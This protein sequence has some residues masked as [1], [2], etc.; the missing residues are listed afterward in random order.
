MAQTLER[1]ELC[2]LHSIRGKSPR[3]STPAGQFHPI[4][5]ERAN[6]QSHMESCHL[7]NPRTVVPGWLLKDWCV[8]I[9]GSER[10]GPALGLAGYDFFLLYPEIRTERTEKREVQ[11]PPSQHPS[12]RGWR[13]QWFEPHAGNHST[14]NCLPLPPSRKERERFIPKNR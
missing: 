2:G 7:R 11:T 4:Q 13:G 6:S 14:P 8:Q 10:G 9:P 3:D 5:R 12:G 1:K